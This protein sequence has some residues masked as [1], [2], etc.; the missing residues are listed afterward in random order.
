[1]IINNKKHVI[2]IKKIKKN[3]YSSTYERYSVQYMN[4]NK[5]HNSEDEF[6]LMRSLKKNHKYSQRELADDLGF[7]L[8]KLNYCLKALQK[9]GL[10]K[11]N[12]FKN[13]K[14]KI[15]YIY[16]LTPKGI[17]AKTKL[18]INFM[19]KKMREYDELRKEIKK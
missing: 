19:R 5:K 2:L 15:N 7:S 8:G 16:L 14:N 6:N 12:N 13:N 1:M 10:V 3:L 17:A 11:I 4:T 18:T 9:K